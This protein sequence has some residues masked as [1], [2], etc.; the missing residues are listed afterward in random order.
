M[1]FNGRFILLNASGLFM[2]LTLTTNTQALN[3]ISLR[4]SPSAARVYPKPHTEQFL[5]QMKNNIEHQQKAL[6]RDKYLEHH[7]DKQKAF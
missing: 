4:I 5:L 2:G 7:C 1:D 6:R 3:R